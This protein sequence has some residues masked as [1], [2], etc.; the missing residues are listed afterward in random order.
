MNE[1]TSQQKN[2]TAKQLSTYAKYSSL[3]FQMLVIIGLSVFAGIALD[4]SLSWE[5]PV[6]KLIFSLLGVVMAVYYSIKDFIH[7]KGK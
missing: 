6:F 5:F 4:N 3:A 1:K 2:R 7:P